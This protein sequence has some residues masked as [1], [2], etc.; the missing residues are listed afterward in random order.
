MKIDK[1]CS[2]CE[3]FLQ[4]YINTD[5]RGFVK[6][7]GHCVMRKGLPLRHSTDKVCEHFKEKLESEVK[8]AKQETMR[9]K[10]SQVEEMLRKLLE[11][12]EHT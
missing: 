11:Y 7:C 12:V 5:Y 9:Y 10:I 6:T 4:H 3:Y 2:Q 8:T 1:Q